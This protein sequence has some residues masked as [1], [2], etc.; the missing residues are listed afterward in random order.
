MFRIRINSNKET[1]DM[2]LINKMKIKINKQNYSVDEKYLKI[3]PEN[4]CD[5]Y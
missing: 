5:L 1:P 2:I 3:E 4:I